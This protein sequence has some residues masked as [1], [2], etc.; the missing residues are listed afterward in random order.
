MENS[1][2]SWGKQETNSKMI[3]LNQGVSGVTSQ[4]NDTNIQIKR[5][6]WLT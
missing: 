1:K 4:V 6:K 5:Q 3:D 2:E